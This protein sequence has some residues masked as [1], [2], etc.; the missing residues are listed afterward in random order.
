MT[1]PY[2]Q[3]G[4]QSGISGVA[5]EAVPSYH[6]GAAG[7]MVYPSMMPPPQAYNLEAASGHSGQSPQQ[8][9][10]KPEDNT[11]A[12]SSN[13][14]APSSTTSRYHPASAAALGGPS[15]SAAES[16]STVSPAMTAGMSPHL[17]TR[18]RQTDR[19][20]TPLG[21]HSLSSI[22]SPYNTTSTE[23][24]NFHAQTLILGERLRNA[25][26]LLSSCISIPVGPATVETSYEKIITT[27]TRIF[28]PLR[29]QA[30][31]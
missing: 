31:L 1:M 10:T 6:G 7:S 21:K 5:V 12:S 3:M 4:M 11:N 24:K 15:S 29:I 22:T 16:G 20:T 27:F 28:T 26:Q 17:T 14:N 18:N 2:Y 8:R 13:I 23:S 9:Y 30:H 25:T 19:P